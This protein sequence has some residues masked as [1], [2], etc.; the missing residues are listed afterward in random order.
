MAKADL[1]IHGEAVGH[2]TVANLLVVPD[3]FVEGEGDLL[4]GLELDNVDDLL[5]FD[6]RQLDEAGQAGLAGDGHGDDVALGGVALEELLEGLAGELVGVGVGLGED[7]GV[8]DVFERGCR[9]D[10]VDLFE[11]KGLQG[12]LTNVDAPD[13]WINGHVWNTPQTGT[14]ERT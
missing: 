12:T 8:F 11:P 7:L 2:Y 14:K 4:L 13:A 6:R 5:L 3:D 10:A 1:R 9:D